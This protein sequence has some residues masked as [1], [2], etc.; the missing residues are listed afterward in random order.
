M[1]FF[2]FSKRYGESNKNN[3][4]HLSCVLSGLCNG[5]CLLSSPALAARS[6]N[7]ENPRICLHNTQHAQNLCIFFYEDF[8]ILCQ[9]TL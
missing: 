7:I 1:G 9:Y 2:H 4:Q 5:G 6:Q 8:R 3:T